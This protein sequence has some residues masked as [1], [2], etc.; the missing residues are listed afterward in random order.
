MRF[1]RS[2]VWKLVGTASG[3]RWAAW[4][5]LLTAN[6][7]LVRW[8]VDSPASASN[9]VLV[10]LAWL[11]GAL[12]AWSLS[13]VAG[14]AGRAGPLADEPRSALGLA[15]AANAY[16]WAAWCAL[17]VGNFLLVRWLANSPSTPSSFIVCL[18]AGIPGTYFAWSLSFVTG[19][20]MPSMERP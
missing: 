2:P 7:A 6:I 9:F 11:P 13:I 20:V 19:R 15:R 1:Y 5:V 17:L 18:L 16:R 10:F 12:F 14:R 8:L 4:L 3:Y